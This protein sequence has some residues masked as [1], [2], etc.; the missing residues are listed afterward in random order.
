VAQPGRKAQAS[1]DLKAAKV[2]EASVVCVGR[3]V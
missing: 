2:R 3:K 1:P